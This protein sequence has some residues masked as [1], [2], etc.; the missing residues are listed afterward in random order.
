VAKARIVIKNCMVEMLIRMEEFTRVEDWVY[1]LGMLKLR[2]RENPRALY[3]SMLL[4]F[5]DLLD[6]PNTRITA[7]QSACRPDSRPAW[8]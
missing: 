1:G 7:I 4:D 2:F 6:L 5:K 8:T 3:S